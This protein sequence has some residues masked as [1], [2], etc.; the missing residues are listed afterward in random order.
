[1]K[2]FL[3]VVRCP[4]SV[5]SYIYILN[6]SSTHIRID[7]KLSVY[8][9]REQVVL[10]LQSNRQPTKDYLRFRVRFFINFHQFIYTYMDILLSRRQTLM[11]Q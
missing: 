2:H 7:F 9:I 4:L 10:A 11:T 3:S 6:C 8:R 5:V 1:M